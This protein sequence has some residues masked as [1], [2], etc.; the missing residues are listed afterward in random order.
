[1]EISEDAINEILEKSKTSGDLSSLIC[2]NYD[3][4]KILDVIIKKLGQE[5]EKEKTF[6]DFE[7]NNLLKT[8][9]RTL[10]H[11]YKEYS[12]IEIQKNSVDITKYLNSSKIILD[13]FYENVKNTDVLYYQSFLNLFYGIFRFHNSIEKYDGIFD[14]M[15]NAYSDPI[16]SYLLKEK[17][18]KNIEINTKDENRYFIDGKE[19]IKKIVEILKQRKPEYK[20]LKIFEKNQSLRTNLLTGSG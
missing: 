13:L 14:W 8:I 6:C 3:N 7:F 10:L 5:S 19:L 2:D 15:E 9:T 20:I 12:K 1:M 16:L 11:I 4:V 17:Y 18:G